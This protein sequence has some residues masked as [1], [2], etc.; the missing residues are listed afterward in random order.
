MRKQTSRT[1]VRS[2][3]R[4]ELSLDGDLTEKISRRVIDSRKDDDPTKRYYSVGDY[5]ERKLWE[6]IEADE[7]EFGEIPVNISGV[8]G[9]NT[10]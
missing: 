10:K 9:S 6:A 4:V 7:A 5:I 8:N 1:V 2:I 3:D